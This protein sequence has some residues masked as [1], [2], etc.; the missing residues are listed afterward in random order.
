MGHSLTDLPC[1][2]VFSTKY[3]V[4]WIEKRFESDLYSYIL[5]IILHKKGQLI[6]I[7]GI[8]DH[9]HILACFH[10][11]RSIASMVGA[12]KSN[13]SSY[14]KRLMDNDD[15]SWQTGYAAFNVSRSQVPRVRTYIQKQREHHK[16]MTYQEEIRKLCRL[17]NV[18]FDESFFEEPS[19]SRSDD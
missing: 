12:I 1:H 14:G 6:E 16:K 19:R 2:L 10:Q 9:V 15:F 13:S 17:H 3:R 5:G 11:S 18:N 7:G 8:E 4:Q